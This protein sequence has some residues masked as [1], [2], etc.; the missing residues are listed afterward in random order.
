MDTATQLDKLSEQVAW[1]VAR[2]ERQDELWAELMPVGRHVMTSLAGRLDAAEKKGY[3]AFGRELLTVGERVLDH[4]SADDVRRLGEAIVPI[5]DAV[6]ALTQPSMMTV[7]TDTAGAVEP[8]QA[9]SVSMFGAMRATRDDDVRRGLGIV[10]EMLRRLG[11][12]A[13]EPR[14]GGDR[15]ERLARVLGPRRRPAR[16]APAAAVTAAPVVAAPAPAAAPVVIGGV[17]FTG[18]GY[19]ADATLWTREIA[20]SLAQ[21]AGLTLSEQHWRVLDAARADYAQTKSSPNIRRLTQIQPLGT[22]DLYALFP[23]APGR[24]IAKLAGLPKPTG[25]L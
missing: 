25:C 21:A 1:L 17:P 23:K 10:L 3:L 2:Q 19:L 5:L 14:N 24:T 13:R 9:K 16:A 22:K 12:D 20:E 6:R 18:D 8:G 15:K 4:Y 7:A 11:R